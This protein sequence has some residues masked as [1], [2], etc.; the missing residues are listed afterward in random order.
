MDGDGFLPGEF[1]AG[2]RVLLVDG[3]PISLVIVKKLLR[4]SLYEGHILQLFLQNATE[5]K[6]LCPCLERRKMGLI[7]LCVMFTCLAWIGL[8]FLDCVE[9]EM[10]IP[11]IILSAD[12][13][14]DDLLKSVIH[15][16]SAFYVKPVCPRLVQSISEHVFRK[17]VKEWRALNKSTLP[18]E[19]F[20]IM[21]QICSKDID[22]V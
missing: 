14:D 4:T 8:K 20:Q 1:P 21:G 12:E 6:R 9:R 19:H 10:D 2:L 15:G 11:V 22:T 13:G 17:K 16:T 5:Q 18:S 7:L 3:D